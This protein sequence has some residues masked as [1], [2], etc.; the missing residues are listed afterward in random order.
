MA[1]SGRWA[2]FGDSWLCAHDLMHHREGDTGRIQEE[3]VTYGVESWIE[4]GVSEDGWGA[5]SFGAISGPIGEAY[6]DTRHLKHF[7]VAEP[8]VFENPLPVLQMQQFAEAVNVGFA[9]AASTIVA[10]YLDLYEQKMPQA[11]VDQL[12]SEDNQARAVQWM[13]YGYLQ[14]QTRYPDPVAAQAMFEAVQRFFRRVFSAGWTQSSFKSFRLDFDEAALT[15]RPW[16]P[17]LRA[18]WEEARITSA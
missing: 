12:V 18:I 7:V 4:G 11:V 1:G 9:D 16:H 14:A 10:R 2:D 17:Q 5:V 8:P 3:M 6:R 13:A 15:L